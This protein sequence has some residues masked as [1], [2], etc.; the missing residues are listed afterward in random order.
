MQGLR[1]LNKLPRR[2]LTGYPLDANSYYIA[3]SGGGY[4]PKGFKVLVYDEGTIKK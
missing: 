3:A 4:N 2:R 1:S